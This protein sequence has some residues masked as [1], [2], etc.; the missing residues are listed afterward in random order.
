MSDL[1]TNTILG[2]ALASLLVVMGLRIGVADAFHPTMPAKPGY[3]VDIS[4]IVATSGGG[5]AAK[6]EEGPVDWGTVLADP[7]LVAQGEKITVVCQSCHDFTKG[8]PNKTGPNLYGVVGRTAGTHPGFNYSASMKAYAQP[9]TYDN[10]NHFITAPQ[11][12]VKGTLMTFA[13]L[14]SQDQRSAVIAYLRSLAD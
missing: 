4:S 2:T 5:G 9:W 13:G 1:R 12:D 6:K 11:K 3:D 7:A 10:I 8:G 14:K